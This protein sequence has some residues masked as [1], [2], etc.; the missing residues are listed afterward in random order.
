MRHEPIQESKR[1][2]NKIDAER[3]YWEVAERC[4]PVGFYDPHRSRLVFGPVSSSNRRG[5]RDR[6]SKP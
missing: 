1:D 4:A 5:S 3:A 2:R 6:W